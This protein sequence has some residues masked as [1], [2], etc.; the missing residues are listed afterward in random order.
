MA[1][2]RILVAVALQRYSDITPLAVA[3]REVAAEHARAS[4]ASLTVMTV[5]FPIAKISEARQRTEEKL[6][7]FITL[8]VEE[9]LEVE[10]RVVEDSP[11][12]MISESRE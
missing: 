3:I 9:G 5:H 11:R 8:L 1:G 6:D 12:V 4:G 10:T 2:N 7:R